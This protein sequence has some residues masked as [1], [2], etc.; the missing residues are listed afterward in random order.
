GYHQ[1][2]GVVHRYFLQTV[3]KTD[4]HVSDGAANF[5]RQPLAP[6]CHP[7][8]AAILIHAHPAL[9]PLNFFLP[10]AVLLSVSITRFCKTNRKY[11]F[12]FT[13]TPCFESAQKGRLKTGFQTASTFTISDHIPPAL[14]CLP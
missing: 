1:G 3:L 2:F 11:A 8:T 4:R 14:R 12:C 5:G 10:A 7:D 6:S 13:Q 9:K